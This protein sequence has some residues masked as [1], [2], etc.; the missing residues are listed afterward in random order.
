MDALFQGTLVKSN[1][2][3]YTPSNFAR[4]NLLH[5][6]EVGELQA[7][8]PH[9]SGR[10]NLASYLCF[11]IING[12]GI[13]IYHGQEYQLTAGDCVF[14]DCKKSYSHRSAEELWTLKWVHFYGPNMGGIYEKYMERGGQPVFRPEN[15][16]TFRNLLEELFYIAGSSDYIRDMR[17]SEKLTSLLT[18]LMAESWHPENHLNIGSKRQSLQY[19]KDY[20]EQH[21]KE[22]ITLDGLAE[23]FYINKFYLS[24]IFKEQFGTTINNYLAQIRI[25][26]A[27]QLLR[28]TAL[29]V[30]EIGRECGIEEPAYFARVFKKVEGVSPGEYRKM[31]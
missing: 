28:F 14:I 23:K 8:K 7:Q 11:T 12:S 22:K 18:L 29:T 27:K 20:L 5:L 25:T 21:Y 9:T 3:I 2:I 10:E 15:P 30:E 6:Q 26:H 1:R 13:L 31:W 24:R 4:T 16:N 17:I 19:M